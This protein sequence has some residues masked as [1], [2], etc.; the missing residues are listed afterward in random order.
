M[1]YSL[2]RLLRE[3]VSVTSAIELLK[4]RDVNDKSINRRWLI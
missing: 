3:A 1:F 2:D 4:I